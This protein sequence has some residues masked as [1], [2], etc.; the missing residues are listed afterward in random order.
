MDTGFQPVR[1]PVGGR[2][3]PA[4]RIRVAFRSGPDDAGHRFVSQP[5]PALAAVEKT[6]RH[7]GFQY[8]SRR[9]QRE[10]KASGHI[11]KA[12]AHRVAPRPTHTVAAA[13]AGILR[14]TRRTQTRAAHRLSCSTG[15]GK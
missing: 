12:V 15:Y 3:G 9:Y 14:A 6:T 5:L 13:A 7:A 10:G 2:P 11:G 8:R 4:L 1:R